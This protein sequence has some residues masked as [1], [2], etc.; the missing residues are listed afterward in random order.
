MYISGAARAISVVVIHVVHRYAAEIG[1]LK[2]SEVAQLLFA[3]IW[4]ALQIDNSADKQNKVKVFGK[5]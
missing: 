2:M 3:L 4:A 5:S 1:K